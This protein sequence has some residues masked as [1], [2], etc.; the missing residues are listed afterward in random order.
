MNNFVS[1]YIWCGGKPPNRE[2]AQKALAEL[3]TLGGKIKSE[4]Q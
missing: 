4:H 3:R 1:Y 2:E